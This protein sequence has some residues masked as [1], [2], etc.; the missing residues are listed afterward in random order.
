MGSQIPRI[1][2]QPA[3]GIAVADPENEEVPVLSRTLRL[4]LLQDLPPVFVI[5]VAEKNDQVGAFSGKD[6]AFAC[7]LAAH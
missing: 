1:R 7:N 3:F 6:P 2:S 5:G 4:I